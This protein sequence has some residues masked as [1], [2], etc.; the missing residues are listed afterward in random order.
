MTR[1]TLSAAVVLLALLALLASLIVA[2]QGAI[3]I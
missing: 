1:D 3:R 2:G